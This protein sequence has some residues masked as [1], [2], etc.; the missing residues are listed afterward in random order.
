[1]SP[2]VHALISW[3]LGI[4]L[5]IGCLLMIAGYDED[6]AERARS[7]PW[8]A[9]GWPFFA[10]AFVGAILLDICDSIFSPPRKP[11][12]DGNTP[13]EDLHPR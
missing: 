6:P 9:I 3:A 2:L 11:P 7:W 13:P 4:W 10:A 8:P 1:M 5:V 12:P